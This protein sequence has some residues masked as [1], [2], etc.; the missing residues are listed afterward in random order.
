[1]Y[2]RPPHA[3]HHC[4]HYSYVRDVSSID[5]QGP[6]CACGLDLREKPGASQVCMPPNVELDRKAPPPEPCDWREEY[7]DAERAA[8]EAWREESSKRMFSILPLLPGSS[9]KK[10]RASWG[11]Q[12]TMACPACKV[13]TI[14]W[15]R[16]RVNGHIHAGCSTPHCFAIMQ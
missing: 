12:G 7:T 1:M 14:R 16:A 3:T 8:W 6:H 10:D 2:N 9:N 5:K 11:T 13:G 4:R 15:V